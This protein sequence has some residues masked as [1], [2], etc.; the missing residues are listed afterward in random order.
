MIDDAI[1]NGDIEQVKDI[2]AS[3][4]DINEETSILPL[5][6]ASSRGHF[7][8]VKFLLDSGAEV[9]KPFQH[10]NNMETSLVIAAERGHTEIVKLL[11][12]RGADVNY[13]IPFNK[14]AYNSREI[15][16]ILKDSH[17]YNSAL[18]KQLSGYNIN[19]KTVR[20]LLDAGA[21][22]NVGFW[23]AYR[24]FHTPLIH[25]C[26]HGDVEIVQ[27][28][29]DRG[30]NLNETDEWLK[31]PLM[32]ALEGKEYTSWKPHLKVI[33]ALVNAGADPNKRDMGLVN[34]KGHTPLSYIALKSLCNPVPED[35]RNLIE[36]ML[37]NGADPY[38]VIST[39]PA[40]MGDYINHRVVNRGMITREKAVQ[41]HEQ[42]NNQTPCDVGG[43]RK[44]RDLIRIYDELYSQ[45]L[46]GIKDGSIT[47]QRAGELGF[48]ER[49]KEVLEKR[50]LLKEAVENMRIKAVEDEEERVKNT[51]NR[52]RNFGTDGLVKYIE[53][54]LG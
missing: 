30:A 24:K 25:A 31:S 34:N 48:I 12:E 33:R 54:F 47:E 53:T 4:Y 29:I 3:G 50:F 28:L 35:I 45:I 14:K 37:D 10:G 41:M 36:F 18:T 9:D 52:M 2:V 21:N 38:P 49:Y 22:V 42:F 51:N 32:Y 39:F 15:N 19:I 23:G 8:I 7:D 20:A 44:M 1:K 6:L 11:V 5:A 27:A 26:V 40:R 13:I 16:V 46:K 43:K 17:P